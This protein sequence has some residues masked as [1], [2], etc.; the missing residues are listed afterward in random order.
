[1]AQAKTDG[2]SA[3]IFYLPD[4]GTVIPPTANNGAWGLGDGGQWR[5]ENHYPVF[6][7]P[8]TQG[9]EVMTALST[10]S[11]KNL[12]AVPNGVLLS[13]TYGRN[14]LIWPF[15]NIGLGASTGHGN[16][17]C[18]DMPPDDAPTLPSLWNFILIILGILLFFVGAVSLAMHWFQRRRRANLRSRVANGQVDLAELGIVKRLTVPQEMLDRLPLQLYNSNDKLSTFHLQPEKQSRVFITSLD[19]AQDDAEKES[20]EITTLPRRNSDST[21]LRASTTSE[22]T[23]PP[24]YVST[25]PDPTTT[26]FGDAAT[27]PLRTSPALASPSRFSQPTCA[28][29]LDDFVPSRTV[30]RVLPCAHVFHPDCVDDFLVKTSA[31]CPMC[32]ASVLPKGYCPA[33]I[34]NAMVRRERRL[35]IV[36]QARLERQRRQEQTYPSRH[37][38]ALVA[39]PGI[40]SDTRAR[41][42]RRDRVTSPIPTSLPSSRLFRAP[43]LAAGRRVFSAPSP[44][45]VQLH[46]VQSESQF[47]PIGAGMRR[48]AV[49]QATIQDPSV[50]DLSTLGPQ[51]TARLAQA[52]SRREWAWQRALTPMNHPA[53]SSETGDAATVPTTVAE[54]DGEE[55]RHRSARIRRVFATVFPGFR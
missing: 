51:R 29:C 48:A 37:I 30:I 45:T 14:A 23:L 43:L 15:V 5:S 18:T 53:S 16:S 38:P 46:H 36:R 6:A 21:D 40:Q 31:L 44:A 12:S 1:M 47:T 10:Y 4:N 19:L 32:K 27:I 7:I 28:I 34:T 8:G 33:K 39:T 9:T 13:T 20:L 24:P 22:S 35:Q 11:G 25:N 17:T 26:S 49:S 42:W 52:Q 3:F 55:E 50:S 2:A 54:I 41:A